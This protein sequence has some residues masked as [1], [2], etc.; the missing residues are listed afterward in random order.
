MLDGLLFKIIELDDGRLD[1]VV[2]SNFK[3]AYFA[4]YLSLQYYWR[5]FWYYKVLP[6]YK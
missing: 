5:T 2:Y 1:S 4:T 3:S 6:D